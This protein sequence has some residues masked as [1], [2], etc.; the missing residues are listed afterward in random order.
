MA[1]SNEG[2]RAV[3]ISLVG[4]AVSAALQVVVVLISGSVVLLADTVHNLSD[5][6]HRDPIVDRVRP[7]Q[8]GGHPPVHLRIRTGGGPGRAVR[9]H[10]D[11][12]VRHGF[13]RRLMDAVD[14]A[15]IDAAES[16]LAARPGVLPVRAVRMRWI[17]HQLHAEAELTIDPGTSLEQAHRLPTTPRTP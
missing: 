3:K 13:Y 10:H 4:L 17:G 1:S 12:P 11:R 15:L 9:R 8:A 7:G 2:I 6:P 14:P 5:G 16:A